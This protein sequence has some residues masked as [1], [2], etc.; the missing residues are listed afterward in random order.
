MP[1][2]AFTAPV[3]GPLTLDI[4]AAQMELIVRVVPG[5]PEAS[6][7]LNGPAEIVD[8][9]AA[10]ISGGRWMVTLPDP[11]PTVV[12][13][14]GT[15]F[16]N[17][18]VGTVV[19]GTVI[20]GGI[21]TTSGTTIINGTVVSGGRTAEPVT[22]VVQMPEG[23]ALRSRIANGAVRT[24][25]HLA[26][27]DHQ[28][29]NTSLHVDSATDVTAETHNGHL[30]IDRAIG[31]VDA[32]THNGGITVAATGTHTQTRTHNGPVDI[33]AAS[34]GPISARTHNGPITVHTNGHRPNVRTRTHNGAERVL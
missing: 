6:L 19:T 10:R 9:A 12:A 4:T 11:E 3:A 14:G 21:M 30:D 7:S 2:R 16:T 29:H 15:V 17:T 31:T 34:D 26:E 24:T 23:S 5:L 33:T 8:G 32:D 28:G 18:G 20:N 25:G 27:V 22:A 1:T 13:T